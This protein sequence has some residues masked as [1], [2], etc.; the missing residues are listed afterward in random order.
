MTSDT[1]RVLEKIPYSWLVPG[2]IVGL[3]LIWIIVPVL[4]TFSLWADIINTQNVP[5]TVI[6]MFPMF[7]KICFSSMEGITSTLIGA[8]V[9]GMVFTFGVKPILNWINHFLC[10]IADWI[11]NARSGSDG[12]REDTTVSTGPYFDIV[13]RRK[14]SRN[15][16][17][18]YI[19]FLQFRYNF[20]SSTVHLVETFLFLWTS[21]IGLFFMGHIKIDLSN[22]YLIWVVLFWVLAFATFGL[23][24]IYLRY[25]RQHRESVWGK[26]SG[27]QA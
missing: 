17:W 16:I 22:T 20:T 3:M 7:W 18:D 26:L 6:M 14:A 21:L 8:L 1:T 4:W 12:K 19:D 23:G 15:A 11:I 27:G 25:L 24:V 5:R 2:F 13:K 10:P 9:S